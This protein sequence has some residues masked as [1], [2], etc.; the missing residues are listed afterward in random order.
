MLQNSFPQKIFEQDV[1]FVN[2]VDLSDIA[3][4]K[5]NRSLVSGKAIYIAE[6]MVFLGNF[7]KFSNGKAYNQ[8]LAELLD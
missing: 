2:K 4:E 6:A 5:L 3:E 8:A 1:I 7:E